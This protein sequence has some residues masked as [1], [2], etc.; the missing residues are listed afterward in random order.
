MGLWTFTVMVS[1]GV[2]KP[3]V[4]SI[5]QHTSAYVNICP[6]TYA[7]VSIHGR[8]NEGLFAIIMNL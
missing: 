6:H 3:W 8:T 7:Y 1:E 4:D 5:R 2:R